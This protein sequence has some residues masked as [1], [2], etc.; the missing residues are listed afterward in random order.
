MDKK[1][2][3]NCG[4]YH[5]KRL[6]VK[7]INPMNHNRYICASCYEKLRKNIDANPAVKKASG[8]TMKKIYQNGG[9]RLEY[10]IKQC[11]KGD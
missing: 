8:K 11:T 1:I 6:M 2:C 7:N 5:D 3:Y 10:L 4:T 9:K